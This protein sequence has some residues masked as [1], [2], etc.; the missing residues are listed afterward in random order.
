MYGLQNFQS[1]R[2]DVVTESGARGL[3]ISA[4]ENYWG[5]GYLQFGMK[6]SNNLQGDSELNLGAISP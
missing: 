1:V 6:S 5:P 2:Y 3:V 4:Q